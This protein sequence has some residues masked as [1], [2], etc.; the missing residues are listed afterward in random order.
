[1]RFLE[2]LLNIRPT[3]WPRLLLLFT[4][5]F[6]VVAGN[7]W[8]RTIVFAAFLQQ[9]GVQALPAVL[10]IGSILTLIATSIYAAFADRVPNDKLLI[11][12]LAVAVAGMAGGRL[13]LG[14]ELITI[15]YPLLYLLF[16]V[17]IQGAF[18]LHWWTYVNSYYDTRSAKR[19]IPIV[20]T[21]A[22]I[23][24]IVGGLTMPLLNQ[25]LTPPDIVVVWLGTLVFT[26]VLAGLM[27]YLLGERRTGSK[28]LVYS[29]AIE[30]TERQS[31]LGN[32][33]EG[34]HYV[35]QSAYLRWLAVSTFLLMM[36]LA[37]LHY[38]SGEIF[39]TRL[40]SVE[41]LSNL[42]GNI[43]GFANLIMLPLQLFLL[44]RIIGRIGLG[45]ANLIFPV[46][47][48]AIASGLIF[49][50]GIPTALLADLDYNILRSSFQSPIESL[51]YNAVPLRVKG[52]ARGFIGGLVLPAGSLLGSSL[53]LLP[54]LSVEWF[55]PVMI[56]LL[57]V[58]FVGSALVIR[59]RYA[60]ALITLLEQ[61]DF[62]FL[63]S[64]EASDLIVTDS[65]TLKSLEKKLEESTSPEFTIFMAKLISDIGGNAA[66]PI[67]ATAT[68][69]GD[70]HVRSTIVDI[71]VA[72]DVR[73]SAVHQLYSDL[74]NDSEPQVRQS[75][76]LG[77]K[78][79]D[80]ED[81]DKFRQL[82]LQCL[83]DNTTD[84]RAQVLPSLLRARDSTYQAPAEQALAEM[85]AS[86]EPRQRALAVHGL[87]KVGH[88]AAIHKLV[89]F[90]RDPEDAV[91]LEVAIAIETLSEKKLPEEV[92]PLVREQM[93]QSHQDPI[94][95]VRQAVLI[96]LGRI[97]SHE[98]HKT[99][100]NALLDPSPR[101]RETAVEVLSNM[102]KAVIPTVHPQ[103]D[104]PDS[105]LRKMA[106]MI[107]SGVNRRE[108]GPL[109]TSYVT[110]NLLTVYR[111]YGQL[112][113]LSLCAKYPSVSILQNTLREQ[114][115]QLT[116]EIF[117]LLTALHEP[118]TL[119]LVSQSL[120]AEDPRI[121]ANAAEALESLTTPQTATL[122][123]PLLEPGI[124]PSR[125]I[126]L[127][128]EVWDMHHPDAREL[129]RDLLTNSQDI[130]L[131]TVA[132]FALGEIGATTW[133]QKTTASLPPE[134]PQ[135]EPAA[136]PETA[137]L[138]RERKRRGAGDLLGAL[139]DD[140]PK[141]SPAQDGPPTPPGGRP[142]RGV[143]PLDALLDKPASAAEAAPA[144]PQPADIKETMVGQFTIDDLRRLSQK[145]DSQAK[146]EVTCESLFSLQEIEALL[147][148]SLVHPSA[149]VQAAAQAA[150]RMLSGQRL[151]DWA[152]KEEPVLSTIEKIIFL[153][154][155]PFFQG[156]TVDQL[157]VLA[158]VCEEEFFPEDTR[159]YNE[160]DPGGVLYVVVSGR[161]GI[162][163][164]GMRKGS[165]ARVGTV[166]AHSYFGEM[167]LFDN[168]P[169]DASAI[170][171]QDT[172]TLRLRREPLIAL[173]RQHPD[174]SLEL[175]NVLS[176]RL[177][178]TTARIAN[179]TRSRPRELHKL[180]DQFEE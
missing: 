159:I 138:P 116:E 78:H 23:A 39:E 99:L 171:I 86:E 81:S 147:A 45:N 34:F 13:L 148:A 113:A 9:V 105:Q 176:Q 153:K 164:E 37:F 156:M 28:S 107:L 35:S 26:A 89:E 95:R 165:Y 38:Q 151:T 97:G 142:R 16:L 96:V 67:L 169:R 50:P 55:V 144:R 157:K 180:F 25:L 1:M 115:E 163:R 10:V 68:Q 178:E 11:A 41:E 173:A 93:A 168:S 160:N 49:L 136:K 88:A 166:E 134:A 132:T 92:A 170:A 52:R 64:Q 87:G 129:L 122:I 32:L 58:A 98:S 4:M 149:D 146:G 82:A 40:A 53:L 69:R 71:L 57:A 177:R 22:R 20:A 139:M 63:L 112:E 94:E 123:T 65:A 48:L 131:R 175:I 31:F 121:R 141:E 102:G 101:V 12:I 14:A 119:D 44:S 111:N 161:V 118:E 21:A 70:A 80:G 36:L 79:L 90:L 135:S 125:L 179:L 150:N 117:Y 51:L 17:V 108:Y 167:N 27:P 61:E 42:V 33:R 114:S 56:G 172:L 85:L 110:G 143:N 15:A 3:E 83:S 73:D 120:R 84:V 103:L 66:V 106:V 162:E 137:E 154:E 6:L 76:I 109:I 77:L 124:A 140:S 30:E 60:Q 130:W 104:S 128:R 8:G 46:T 24:G 7:T 158:R 127:S 126:E 100:I 91:R 5:A 174:L 18:F 59:Q 133:A 43:T 75:A 145:E 74:L 2:K 47:T 19:I 155:V 54:L 62:S 152:L 29:P 72:A